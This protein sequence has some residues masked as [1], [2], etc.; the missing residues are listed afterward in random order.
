MNPKLVLS[1]NGKLVEPLWINQRE[2][3]PTVKDI[4]E[5]AGE[6]AKAAVESAKTRYLD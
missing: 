6:M 5:E 2:P 1:I 4:I 3:M